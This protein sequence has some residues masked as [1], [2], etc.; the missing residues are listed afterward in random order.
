MDKYQQGASHDL[1]KRQQAID[2]L[3]K[4]LGESLTKVDKRM[5][6]IERERS[7]SHASLSEHLRL[8]GSAQAELKTQTSHLVQ[9]LRAPS[10]RGRWGEIQLKRVVE[11]AGMTNYCDFTEQET[12]TSDERKLRPD[13]IVRLPNGKS[14]VIDSKAPLQAYLEGLESNDEER[15][16]LKLREHARQIRNHITALSEK[17]YWSELPVT[18]EFVVMFLPGE[19]F[20]GAAL[21]QDPGLIEFGVERRVIT[22]TPTTLIALLQAVAFGWKQEQLAE[23]A[24]EISDLG[25]TLYE[26][27]RVMGGHFSKLKDGLEKSVEA[28]NKTLSSLES[29]VLVSARKFK[30]LGASSSEEIEVISTIDKIPVGPS[31]LLTPELDRSI[32]ETAVG[33]D[34]SKQLDR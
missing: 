23:N 31:D 32:S 14:I 18:P 2:T 19:I 20:F 28:Y 3:V 29:R 33:L 9:A 5:E 30:E 21:E 24:K 16:T 13:M 8:L 15:R 6:E 4:P 22:S 17:R 34:D 7:K 10:V 12:V 27:L 11:L 26:R 1:E 25:K